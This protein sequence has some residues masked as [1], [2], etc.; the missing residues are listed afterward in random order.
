MYDK[1]H[2]N[3]EYPAS[4]IAVIPNV[5]KNTILVREPGGDFETMPR[6]EGLEKA[7]TLFCDRS[8]GLISE[9]LRNTKLDKAMII[10]SN[11]EQLPKGIERVLENVDKK[12]RKSLRV[13]Q[14]ERREQTSHIHNQ[15]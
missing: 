12:T 6:V 3:P 11:C 1:L 8:M 10:A 13:K 2:C 15:G 9:S 7:R 14:D 4:C 5:S